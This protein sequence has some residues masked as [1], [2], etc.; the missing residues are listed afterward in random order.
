MSQQMYMYFSGGSIEQLYKLMHMYCWEMLREI[1]YTS[2]ISVHNQDM[3]G[4]KK[5]ELCIGS[6]F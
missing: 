4:V 3:S 6:K 5:A 2:V 1:D